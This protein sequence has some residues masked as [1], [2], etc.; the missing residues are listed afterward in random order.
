MISEKGMKVDFTNDEIDTLRKAFDIL[1]GIKKYAKQN[2]KKYIYT[3]NDEMF[4]CE[5]FDI[6]ETTYTIYALINDEV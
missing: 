2:G 3:L 4:A 5:L 6:M 1:E